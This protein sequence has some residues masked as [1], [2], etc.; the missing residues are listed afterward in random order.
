MPYNSPDAESIIR[1]LDKQSE[2]QARMRK[3]NIQQSM[4]RH[5]WAYRWEEILQAVGVAPSP[6]LD[7]RKAQLH[8]LADQVILDEDHLIRLRRA[9]WGELR[10]TNKTHVPH[11][12]RGEV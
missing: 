1:E 5:D 3:L 9:I 2:R 8:R 10:L 4:L 11:A 12:S 6:R 7:A